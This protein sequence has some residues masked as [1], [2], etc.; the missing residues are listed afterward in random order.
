MELLKDFFKLRVQLLKQK[1]LVQ[2]REREELEK[3]FVIERDQKTQYR[4]RSN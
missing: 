1:L 2:V 4:E 3:A